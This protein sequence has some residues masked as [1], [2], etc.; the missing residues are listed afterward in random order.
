MNDKKVSFIVC[1]NSEF[2]M[3]E[4]RFY[5]DN[6]IIPEGYE[7]EV[8]EVKGAVSMTSGH[9]TGMRSSDAKYKVYIHQDV[10]IRNRNFIQNILELF[11]S[12]EKIGLIGL[13]GTPYMCSGGAMWN[14]VRYGGFYKLDEYIEKDLV[15][16]FFPIKEGYLEMEAVDGLLIATQYD[17][18]WREDVFKKWDFYDVSQSFSFLDAGY[19]VVVPG[20]AT[21]WYYHDCGIVNM[22]NYDGEREK[23]LK[24]YSKYMDERQSQDWETYLANAKQAVIKGFHGPNEELNRLLGYFDTINRED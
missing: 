13:V 8:I 1:T 4:C 11:Q 10:F 20:Q 6:L 22:S 16:S 12:D 19:K 21:D 18:P 5:L 7:V 24:E 17:I 14:G 15:H 23:F 2:Y 3:Q 9:N